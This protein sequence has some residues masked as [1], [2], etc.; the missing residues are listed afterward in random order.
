MLVDSVRSGRSH[1]MTDEMESNGGI[2]ERCEEVWRRP[3][4]RI[5]QP[6]ISVYHGIFRPRWGGEIN[7]NGRRLTLDNTCGFDCTMFLTY[8]LYRTSALVRDYWRNLRSAGQENMAH[9]L[10]MFAQMDLQDGNAAKRVCI[11]RLLRIDRQRKRGGDWLPGPLET[12]DFYGGEDRLTRHFSDMFEVTETSVCPIAECSFSRAGARPV[13]PC[14]DLGFELLNPTAMAQVL[15]GGRTTRCSGRVN[16]GDGDP[17]GY[18]CQSR[19]QCNY[20]IPADGMPP[21]II[22]TLNLMQREPSREMDIP[23]TQSILGKDHTRHND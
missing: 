17:D 21:H 3:G 10:Q 14:T 9:I 16:L 13:R 8:S 18:A 6:A 20:S 7:I 15:N 23:A 5:A 1:Q 4:P 11:L 12:G 2:P 22:F 19:Y